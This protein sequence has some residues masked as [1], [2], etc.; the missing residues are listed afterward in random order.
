MTEQVRAKF[1]CESVTLTKGSRP[2]ADAVFD[3]NRGFDKYEPCTSYS[4]A[5][6]PVYTGDKGENQKFWSATPSGKLEMQVMNQPAGEMFK[7]GKS[8]YLDFTEAD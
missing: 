4:V 5:M 2:A 7:P 3:P 8:Y 1:V 6:M